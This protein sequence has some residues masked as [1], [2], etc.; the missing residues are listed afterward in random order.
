MSLL[1]RIFLLLTA[2]AAFT[3]AVIILINAGLPERAQ[4]TGELLPDGRVAAPEL[5]AVAPDF[6]LTTLDGAEINLA[7]LRGTPLL[8]NFWAT[9]CEPCRV[10]MPI[11]QDFYETHRASGLR[12]LAVNLGETPDIIRRW[13][14]DYGLTFD[15]IL[16]PQQSLAALYQI[17]GQ[18]STYAISPSGIITAIYYGP[19]SVDQ[20]QAVIP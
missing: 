10:E 7:S 3:A 11:L 2:V 18:P 13:V 15:I 6:T 17:R 8:I 14:D 20:L 5:N 12:I 4:F 19:I 9:W 16:D 1:K